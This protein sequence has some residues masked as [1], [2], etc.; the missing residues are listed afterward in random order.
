VFHMRTVHGAAGNSSVFDQRRVLATRWLG[1]SH[2]KIVQ[3]SLG[4]TSVSLQQDGLVS[5]TRTLCMWC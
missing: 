1:K 4:N 5:S 2:M 3:G